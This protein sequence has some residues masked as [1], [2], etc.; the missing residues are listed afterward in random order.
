MKCRVNDP[1]SDRAQSVETGEKTVK[2]SGDIRV[3]QNLKTKLVV[4]KTRVAV[5]FF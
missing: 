4:L 2:P 3:K 5:Q 1:S